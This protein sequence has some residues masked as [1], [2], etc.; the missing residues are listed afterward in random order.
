MSRLNK[1]VTSQIESTTGAS[2]DTN[3]YSYDSNGVL[4]R[5]DDDRVGKSVVGPGV[6]YGANKDSADQTGLNT[7]KLI[8]NEDLQQTSS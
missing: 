6:L 7:I 3:T 4:I 1:I 2:H 8:P 5:H